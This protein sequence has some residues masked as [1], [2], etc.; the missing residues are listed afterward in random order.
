MKFQ[1][2]FKL[3]FFLT[4]TS[5]VSDEIDALENPDEVFQVRGW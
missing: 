3:D 1:L 4:G 2:F 5:P